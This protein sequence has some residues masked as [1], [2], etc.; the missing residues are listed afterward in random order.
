MIREKDKNNKRFN[1]FKPAKLY[2]FLVIIMNISQKISLIII[3]VFC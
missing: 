1:D 2:F 3:R